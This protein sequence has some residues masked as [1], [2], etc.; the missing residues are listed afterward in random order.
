MGSLEEEKL[1]QM[2][3]DFIESEISPPPIYSTSSLMN[4]SLN[5]HQTKH[6]IL[7]EVISCV[8]DAETEVLEKVLKHMRKKMDAKKS[9]SSFKEWLVM[10][11]S[12]NGYDTSLCQTSWLTTLNC[13]AGDYEYI[14]IVMKDNN[15]VESSRLIVDIDFKSQFELARPTAA[16]K[17]LSETLPSVF[18][19]DKHKLNKVISLLCSAAKQSFR[20]RGIHMPPW[21][22]TTYMQSKWF[23][24]KLNPSTTN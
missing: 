5:D 15:G 4:P 10:R 17:K 19:G 3:H 14:G 6:L 20:D 12:L 23:S 21:R 18:V 9:T 22:T 7:Q 11:L 8:S 24:H 13:P 1:F 16:Y 2:V